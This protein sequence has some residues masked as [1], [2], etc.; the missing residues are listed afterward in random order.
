M[1]IHHVYDYGYAPSMALVDEFLVFLA[2]S[3]CLVEG[4]VVVR[5]V[6][7]AEVAVEFMDRHQLDCIDSEFLDIVE[8]CHR[9]FD[10]L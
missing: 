10:I 7:P 4:E 3:I 6:S 9:A 1:V 5:V 2:R 8:L